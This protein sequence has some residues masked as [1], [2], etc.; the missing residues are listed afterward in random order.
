MVSLYFLKGSEQSALPPKA[1]KEQTSRNVRLVPIATQRIAAN[2]GRGQSFARRL[3]GAHQF[4]FRTAPL[5]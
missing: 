2:L 1:D 3:I 5:S 4:S